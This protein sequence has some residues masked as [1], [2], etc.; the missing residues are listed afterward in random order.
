MEKNALRLVLKD[1]HGGVSEVYWNDSKVT[2]TNVDVSFSAGKVPYIRI[3]V[4]MIDVIFDDSKPIKAMVTFESQG[5]GIAICGHCST[6]QDG[7]NYKCL[8]CGASLG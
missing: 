7:S 2:A 1:G 8:S 4:A 5:D 3:E 6:K